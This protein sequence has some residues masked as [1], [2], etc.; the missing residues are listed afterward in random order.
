MYQSAV[1]HTVS[2]EVNSQARVHQVLIFKSSEMPN[3]L[4][5]L[6]FPF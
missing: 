3:V 2:R 1:G 5:G 6:A 4:H